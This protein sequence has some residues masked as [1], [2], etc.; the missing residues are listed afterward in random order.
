[1]H[2]TR[3]ED[4]RRYDTPGHFEM[5]GLR[6]QGGEASATGGVSVS[7]SYFLP[8]GGAE[9]AGSNTEKIYVVLD[10]EVTVTTDDGEATLEA[11]DS[12]R[13]APGEARAIANRGNVVATMLVV[14]VP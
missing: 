4:A 5:A 14:V 9:R 13:L 8:G 3:F 6:L 1:M 2:V 10:G 12:C 11:L 7:L